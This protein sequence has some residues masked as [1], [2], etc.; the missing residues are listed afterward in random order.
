MIK[1]L[2]TN[3][4]QRLKGISIGMTREGQ[5][6]LIITYQKNQKKRMSD[7][8]FEWVFSSVIVAMVG[9]W[10]FLVWWLVQ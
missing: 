4:L 2:D 1:N 6:F 10:G 3:E 9:M 8:V 7:R 5:P